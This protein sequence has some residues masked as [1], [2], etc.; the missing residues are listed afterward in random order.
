MQL[1]KGMGPKMEPADFRR[2]D[3]MAVQCRE[4]LGKLIGSKN[5][6][7]EFDSIFC[8]ATSDFI[9]NLKGFQLVDF[10]H[11]LRTIIAA[12]I[13]DVT[14]RDPDDKE[15]KAALEDI[16][17]EIDIKNIATEEYL[18]KLREEGREV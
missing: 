18:K 9:T 3:E 16:L 11:E 15:A 12:R 7:K 13:K 5:V 14:A 8:R 4:A 1:I 6:N 17:K 10:I 2:L